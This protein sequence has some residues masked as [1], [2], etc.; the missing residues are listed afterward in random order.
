MTAKIV[1]VLFF[2]IHA[3]INLFFFSIVSMSPIQGILLLL[4]LVS[5]VIPLILV[6]ER[7]LLSIG[8]YIFVYPIMTLIVTGATNYSEWVKPII[9]SAVPGVV[10][11]IGFGLIAR[12][13]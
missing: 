10:L 8:V 4:F 7:W 5:F 2:C 9:L 11:I 12:R 6:K 1:L 3:A 13:L